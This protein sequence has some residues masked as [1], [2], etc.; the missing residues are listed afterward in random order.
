M[1]ARLRY[2]ATAYSM[3]DC[4]S[5]MHLDISTA[6]TDLLTSQKDLVFGLANHC[7][8]VHDP[9]HPCLLIR[10]IA[11]LLEATLRHVDRAILDV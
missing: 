11:I 1:L 7:A 5:R 6:A 3:A 9:P 2:F 8:P 4:P 10:L